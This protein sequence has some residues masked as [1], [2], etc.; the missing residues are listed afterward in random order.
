M[1]FNIV[2]YLYVTYFSSS[3]SFAFDISATK[4][5]SICSSAPYFGLNEDEQRHLSHIA[6]H[7]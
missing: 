2:L 4:G 6:P 5:E 7:Q 3:Y 1:L